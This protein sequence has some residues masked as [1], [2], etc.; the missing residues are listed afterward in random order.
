MV[1]ALNAMLNTQ[2]Q[3]LL[4]F[5]SQV[6]LWLRLRL[7]GRPHLFRSSPCLTAVTFVDSIVSGSEQKRR[8]VFTQN[9]GGEEAAREKGGVTLTAPQI[10]LR[11]NK[12][13]V[14]L[15]VCITQ[16]VAQMDVSLLKCKS[17]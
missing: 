16:A 11:Q 5:L 8:F 2:R 7:K 10:L 9:G 17:L 12:D 3:V 4:Y 1:T 14:W 13:Q 15:L 6:G